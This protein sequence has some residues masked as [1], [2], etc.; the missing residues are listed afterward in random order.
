MKRNG[1]DEEQ[2]TDG[3]NEE[4]GGEE[5]ATGKEEERK[6]KEGSGKGRKEMVGGRK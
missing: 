2:E 6:R 4:E 3:Y 5:M 1:A